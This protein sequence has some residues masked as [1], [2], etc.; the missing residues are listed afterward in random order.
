[1]NVSGEHVPGMYES[2]STT[3]VQKEEWACPQNANSNS[4]L[5]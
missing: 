2:L 4:N 3:D 5:M 1:M